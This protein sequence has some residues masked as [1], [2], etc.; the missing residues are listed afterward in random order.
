MHKI[1]PLIFAVGISAAAASSLRVYSDRAYYVYEPQNAFVGFTE[2][3]EAKCKERVVPLERSVACEANGSELCALY[4]TLLSVE[5]EK[6]ETKKSE[7]MLELFASS[8]DPQ[9][10]DASGW[11][12]AAK[13]L[14]RE[15]TK[16]E[17][18]ANALEIESEN[19][20]RAFRKRAPASTP[21]VLQTPCRGSLKLSFPQGYIRFDTEYVAHLKEGKIA[22]EQKIA[23]TNRSGVDINAKEANFY[24]RRS[25]Q[26]IAPVRFRPWI[27]SEARH[28]TA[29]KAVRTL[30]SPA[31]K[32]NVVEQESVILSDAP[33][34]AMKA[35]YE[36]AREY[37]V[38]N[39]HLPS[40]G[41]AIKIP[42][43]KWEAPVVCQEELFAYRN[44]TV[45]EVCRFKPAYQIEK[46]RWRVMQGEE[47]LNANA[48]GAYEEGGYALYTKIDPDIA[49]RRERIVPKERESGIFGGT[50]RKKDGFVLTIV[51]K[52]DKKKTIRITERIPTSDTE[53]ISV[54]LRFVKGTKKIRYKEGKEGKLTMEITLLPNETQKIRVG[55]EISYDKAL[56]VVY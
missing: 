36:D 3:V 19:L 32:A 54:K 48:R 4:E 50:E 23:I 10:M 51:N 33:P 27:V 14:A 37:R 1:V 9:Q 22:V 35:V 53:K 18:Q 6:S 29:K 21:S 42:I 34:V 45:F 7:E 39:L 31:M 16:L 5:R 55:F 25:I 40:T 12:D 11:I 38:E 8:F 24:R 46:H 41:E 56:E 17:L 44:R 13:R 47:L 28:Y 15:R 49:V 26:N 52:S 20:K 30:A 43:L 2:R